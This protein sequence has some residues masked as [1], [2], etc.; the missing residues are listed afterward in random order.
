MVMVEVWPF[1]SVTCLAEVE[2]P[3]TWFPKER[4]VGDTETLWP[5]APTAVARVIIPR[6]AHPAR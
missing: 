6:A 2:V 3:R 4:L 5:R 1:L